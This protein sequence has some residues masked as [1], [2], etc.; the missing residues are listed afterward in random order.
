MK[1]NGPHTGRGSFTKNVKYLAEQLEVTQTELKKYSNVTEQ[2]KMRDNEIVVAFQGLDRIKEF[3][4]T[5]LTDHESAL[6][7]N[8]VIDIQRKMVDVGE[9][10][11]KKI[12]SEEPASTTNTTNT[13]TIPEAVEAKELK[14]LEA[15]K[16]EAVA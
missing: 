15:P 5:H 1:I 16:T 9:P 11:L 12:Y 3:A 4:E 7:I 6:I 10:A 8:Y 13:E 14:E 2:F